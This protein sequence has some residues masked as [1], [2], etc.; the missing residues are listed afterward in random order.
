MKKMNKKQWK[1]LTNVGVVMYENPV[2][3]YKGDTIKDVFH[4]IHLVSIPIL[5]SLAWWIFYI[6][7]RFFTKYEK[8]SSE[9]KLH[10]SEER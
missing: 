1:K 6:Y 5:G 2:K 9:S 10:V 3:D 4:I 7:L 8:F